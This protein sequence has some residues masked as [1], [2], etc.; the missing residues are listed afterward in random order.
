MKSRHETPTS[1]AVCAYWGA[2][3]ACIKGQ[4]ELFYII[5]NTEQIKQMVFTAPCSR[6]KKNVHR[7]KKKKKTA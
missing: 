6:S 7:L 1:R 4:Q 2:C 3:C 5:P